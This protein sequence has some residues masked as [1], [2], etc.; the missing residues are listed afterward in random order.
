MLMRIKLWLPFRKLLV[1]RPVMKAVLKSTQLKQLLMLQ[2]Q[3]MQNQPRK[4]HQ[5]SRKHKSKNQ[6][7]KLLKRKPKMTMIL[8]KNQLTTSTSL[9]KGTI[10][11][12]KT[13]HTKNLIN[14]RTSWRQRK[15]KKWRKSKTK[16][17]NSK[18]PSLKLKTTRKTVFSS[19]TKKRIWMQLKTTTF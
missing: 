12:K 1:P 18:T 3:E 17:M 2:K 15:M 4:Q 16:Q 11:K 14:S 9:W 7:M 10:M 8:L 6:Q 19:V 5:L 13:L